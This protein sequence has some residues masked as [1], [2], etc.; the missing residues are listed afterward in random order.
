MEAFADMSTSTRPDLPALAEGPGGPG[1]PE[2]PGDEGA[3][4]VG[5]CEVAACPPDSIG[6]LP[7]PD[8]VGSMMHTSIGLEFALSPGSV[9][10]PEILPR[11]RS[12]SRAHI[13]IVWKRYGTC[14]DNW[15]SNRRLSRYSTNQV[16]SDE[17]QAQEEGATERRPCKD[18]HRVGVA[19]NAKSCR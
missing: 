2:A 10:H 14:L 15:S 4:P 16:T 17:T 3:K 12:F 18:K 11:A 7:M 1:G 9:L 5:P 19:L 13:L 6:V 8:I